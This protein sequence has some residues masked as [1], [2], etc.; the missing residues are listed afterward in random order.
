MA[1]DGRLF[2]LAASLGRA[3][4]EP[5]GACVGPPLA[6]IR[7]CTQCIL[8]VSI[9]FQG[10]HAFSLK[11]ILF[12]T[13]SDEIWHT[14]VFVAGPR[15][16]ACVHPRPSVR[17]LRTI[18]KKLL[19]RPPT[20]SSQYRPLHAAHAMR[21]CVT[22]GGFPR[23]S[24]GW[25]GSKSRASSASRYA[26]APTAGNNAANAVALARG[27]RRSARNLGAIARAESKCAF[28]TDATSCTA[29]RTPRWV[30]RGTRLPWRRRVWRR[31]RVG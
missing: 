5:H 27:G 22:S 1:R 7:V 24:S 4:R 14:R 21:A 16:P 28:A 15:T 26:P 23:T 17:F 3:L 11:E 13:L 10:T 25:N 8:L 18:V 30:S 20:P 31:R 19:R 9:D 2:S 12:R 29:F 6:S